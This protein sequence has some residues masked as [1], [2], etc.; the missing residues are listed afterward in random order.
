MVTS[1][2]PRWRV[3]LDLRTT[4]QEE[5]ERGLRL[6]GSRSKPQLPELFSSSQQVPDSSSA[7]SLSVK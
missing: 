2:R 4:V 7:F 6:Q 5:V 1:G 3:G